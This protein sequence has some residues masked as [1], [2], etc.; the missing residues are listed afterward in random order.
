MHSLPK[1]VRDLEDH[2]RWIFNSNWKFSISP[3]WDELR[4]Q[5]PKVT[6]HKAI[7]FPGH[8]PKCSMITWLAIHNR[9]YTGDRL[10][11]FGTIPV[12]CCSFCSGVETH[13]HLFFNCIF[14]SQVWSEMLDHVN[15]IW[16]S[17]SWADWINQISNFRD[18]T[19]K[20]LIIKLIFTAT[21]HQIW[22]ERNSRKFQNASCP[23]PTVVSKIHSLVRYRLLSLEKLPH[24]P[25][26]QGLLDKWGIH[27]TNLYQSHL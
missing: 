14:T 5:Y 25:Q 3:L 21:V 18:K 9:L 11:L 1:Q 19:L 4:T 22:L 20:N 26:S 24:G 27:W 12:S 15:V 13:D 7:W 17:R 23:M 2:H 16:P 10:V 8:I 6:W